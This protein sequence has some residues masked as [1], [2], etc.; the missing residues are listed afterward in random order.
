MTLQ[1]LTQ[2][3]NDTSYSKTALLAERL[4]RRGPP[5]DIAIDWI[6]PPTHRAAMASMFA[7]DWFLGAHAG[8][9][10]AKSLLPSQPAHR[11]L[12]EQVGVDSSRL[13]LS[14][15]HTK[16]RV[17]LED[18]AHVVWDCPLYSCMR[19]DF[20]LNIPFELG[21]MLAQVPTSHTK[22]MMILESSNPD[23]WEKF[24]K[25]SFQLRQAR[26]KL[27]TDFASLS[28]RLERQSFS[29]RRDAWRARGR[30]ACRHGVLFCSPPSR[31]CPCMEPNTNGAETWRTA[32]FMPAID[33]R[34]KAIISVPFDLDKFTRLGV[35]QAE[36][37]R[38]GW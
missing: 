38:R 30:K 10:F 9:Y 17:A 29:H 26:R 21:A 25:F 31:S 37:R 35:L 28:V 2:R 36:M 16:R 32:K 13:C 4:T 3:R 27:R 14:C 1:Q 34:L 11:S 24:G 33:E 7:G 5:V 19:E 15:W 18:M 8:N 12:A 22:L 20:V 23:V 6:G